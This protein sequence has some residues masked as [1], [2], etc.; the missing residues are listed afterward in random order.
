MLK[1]LKGG[2]TTPHYI[3]G[4]TNEALSVTQAFKDPANVA[5]LVALW[6][7]CEGI[8][9]ESLEGGVIDRARTALKEFHD[10]VWEL[11]S[12]EHVT[13]AQPET[14]KLCML[15]VQIGGDK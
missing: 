13:G 12:N 7:A 3:D 5:R 10:T 2:T 14:C 1:I 11:M 9:T 15:I 8:S 4:E 6:G